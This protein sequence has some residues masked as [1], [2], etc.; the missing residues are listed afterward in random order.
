MTELV[1]TFED[2]TSFTAWKEGCVD[3][4]KSAATAMSMIRPTRVPPSC[5]AA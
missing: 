1:A 4:V 3:L 5:V 2:Q